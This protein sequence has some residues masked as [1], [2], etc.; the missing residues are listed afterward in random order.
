[1]PDFDDK[2]RLVNEQ[3]EAW[4][5]Y[6]DQ[7]QR[8]RGVPEGDILREGRELITL[9]MADISRHRQIRYYSL[10]QRPNSAWD[11]AE[12]GCY[13]SIGGETQIP[14]QGD[15]SRG[16]HRTHV[17][18]KSDSE[19]QRETWA[20]DSIARTSELGTYSPTSRLL[21]LRDF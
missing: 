16:G 21:S 11:P 12:A 2:L 4:H 7:W 17:F 15:P 19:S 5:V 6:W 20:D 14:D 13:R 10:L 9:N 3:A 8:V 1:L 18:A